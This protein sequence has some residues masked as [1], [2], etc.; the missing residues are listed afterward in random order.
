M[1]R[2]NIF[3]SYCEEFSSQ[4]TFGATGSLLIPAVLSFHHENAWDVPEPRRRWP[5][6]S[7]Q[8][9]R[10]TVFLPAWYTLSDPLQPCA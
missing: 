2:G 9:D 7:C 10:L 6:P 3:L 4:S 8:S 1:P 5:A